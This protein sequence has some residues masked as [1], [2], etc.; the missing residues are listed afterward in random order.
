MASRNG[1]SPKIRGPKGVGFGRA[2]PAPFGF[3]NGVILDGSND[4]F[5]IPLLVGGSLPAAGTFEFWTELA[6]GGELAAALSFEFTTTDP[7]TGTN[8]IEFIFD[9]QG[10]GNIRY[11]RADTGVGTIALGIPTGKVHLVLTYDMPNNV[12]I[13]YIN[14]GA[15]VGGQTANRTPTGLNV[16][17]PTGLFL[18]HVKIGVFDIGGVFAN[19]PMDEIRVYNTILRPDEVA[20]NYNAGIGANPCVTEYLTQWYQFEL[21]EVLDFSAAQ[22]GSDMRLGI[23]DMSGK[24]N[25][26]QPHNMITTPG[27]GYVLQP[28]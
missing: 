14:G 3:G 13:F 9:G 6:F 7:T 2:L 19:T 1:L 28:F 25:H 16:L 24:F 21:F 8:Q 22:D 5:D 11:Y 10:G 17:D 27:T 23:R 15:A 4:Y 12:M 26:A 20:L 18:S